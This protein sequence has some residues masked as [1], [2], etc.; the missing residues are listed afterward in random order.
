MVVATDQTELIIFGVL[1][2]RHLL[3]SFITPV[4]GICN[5]L[6]SFRP[7]REHLAPYCIGMQSIQTRW[8]LII[9]DPNT[10]L[11]IFR[12]IPTNLVSMSLV[13]SIFDD[14]LVL[15]YKLA[16]K[17]ILDLRLRN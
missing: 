7:L 8:A 1:L 17:E 13:H 2:S 14:N 12:T 16:L 5:A 11:R 4:S 9:G 10:S 15:C 6:H 3:S